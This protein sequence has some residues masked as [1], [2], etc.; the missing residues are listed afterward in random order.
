MIRWF[1][2]ELNACILIDHHID[3]AVRSEAV[4]LGEPVGGVDEEPDLLA[5]LPGEVFLG[6]LE[7][8]VDASRIA[9]DGTTMMNLLQP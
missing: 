3:G 5:V 4:H 6:G 9:T 8:L 1:L 7:G 2:L